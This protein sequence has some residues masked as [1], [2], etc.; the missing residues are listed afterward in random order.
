[1]F[2]IHRLEQ[3]MSNI[4]LMISLLHHFKRK[5]S[6]YCI[7]NLKLYESFPKG[8]VRKGG[9]GFLQGCYQ[10]IKCVNIRT[11]SDNEYLTIRQILARSFLFYWFNGGHDIRN[12]CYCGKLN[13]R[14]S[15]FFSPIVY[16]SYQYLR[17]KAEV[18][19]A[20]YQFQFVFFVLSLNVMK[21]PRLVGFFLF[22]FM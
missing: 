22:L 19:T 10:P 7:Q 21:F 12:N 13:L 11:K 1:M 20:L 6:Y 14:I 9:Y 18:K 8:R 4:Y 2:F 5:F 17:R 16:L 3:F 15:P